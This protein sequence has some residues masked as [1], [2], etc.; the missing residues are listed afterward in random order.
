VSKRSLA[1]AVVCAAVSASVVAQE[2]HPMPSGAD[3]AAADVKSTAS[4]LRYQVLKAGEA[5]GKSPRRGDYVKVHYEGR[6]EDGKVFDSSYQRGEP[7]RFRLGRVIEGWNEG[8]A[9]MT[10]GAKWR[11]FI[12]SDLGYGKQGGPGIPPDAALTFDVELI[13]TKA[14]E[15]LPEPPKR[16][17]A[18]ESA[19]ASTTASK[20]QYQTLA[21]GTGEP[22]TGEDVLLVHYSLWGPDEKLLQS[23]AAT[24]EPQ[25]VPVKHLQGQTGLPFM[26]ELL[27]Q[28]KQGEKRRLLVPAE[29][30]FGAQGNAMFPAGA[31]S[32]WELEVAK[33]LKPLPTPDFV[34]PE[35]MKLTK[36]PTGLEYE[37]LKEGT[38]EAPTKADTVVINYAGWLLDGT[39]FDS[40]FGRGEPAAY[41]LARLI[42]GWQEGLQLMKEG[43]IVRLVVPPALGYGKDGK[44]K[45]PG[46]ATLVFYIE[47]VGVQW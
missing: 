27:P 31:S 43:A 20:I 38:G 44:G 24:G 11:L 12:P 42:A 15:P 8:L 40:S 19:K 39:P 17:V 47:L 32:T 36:T 9:L 46:D 37:V 30:A 22:A 7:A 41:P 1:A 23:S 16:F 13:A 14:G 2:S 21:E 28:M 33:I 34:K 5:A 10:P 18:V 4:G 26:R 45:I 29:Q 25:R 3:S 6:F 35:S